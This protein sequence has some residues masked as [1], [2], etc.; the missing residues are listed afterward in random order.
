[1]D[2]SNEAEGVDS[3]SILEIQAGGLGGGGFKTEY[4]SQGLFGYR[5]AGPFSVGGGVEGEFE[6]R[7]IRS[8]TNGGVYGFL[9][10]EGE[11]SVGPQ[12]HYVQERAIILGVNSSHGLYYSKLQVAG[13]SAGPDVARVSV[14]S[15]TETTTILSPSP[16]EPIS[17]G[18]QS[19]IGPLAYPTNQLADPTGFNSLGLFD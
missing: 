10:I 1:M 2:A 11:A 7:S 13:F 4:G 6:G 17:S 3:I 5:H 16:L 12:L 9:S 19:V 15:G 18:L 8:I 14:L